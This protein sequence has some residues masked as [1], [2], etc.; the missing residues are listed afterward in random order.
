MNKQIMTGIAGL[1]LGIVLTLAAT[2]L[3]PVKDRK[4]YVAGQDSM[5]SEMMHGESMESSMNMMTASLK[6]KAGD[7]F[8][9][10]FLTEMIV[11]H[12]GAIE[13]AK[14]AL[15][16]AKHQEIKDLSNNIINAQASEINQMKQWQSQWY[17]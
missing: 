10:A 1:V 17:K 15:T 16:N 6:G 7:E 5:H 12:E 9:K 3:T 11:H 4:D 13:M 8:D 2:S 14:Q